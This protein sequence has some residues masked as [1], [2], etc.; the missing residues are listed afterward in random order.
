MTVFGIIL[1][2]V[3]AIA[4]TMLIMIIIIK[5]SNDWGDSTGT[6]ENFCGGTF[7]V[8]DQKDNVK[9]TFDPYAGK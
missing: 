2:I 9:S 7:T 8:L 3:A 4:L 5:K 6:I 1:G